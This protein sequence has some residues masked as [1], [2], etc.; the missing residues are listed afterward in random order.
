LLEFVQVHTYL[1]VIGEF[2]GQWVGT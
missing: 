2:L 1:V